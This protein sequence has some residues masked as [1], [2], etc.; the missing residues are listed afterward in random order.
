MQKGALITALPMVVVGDAVMRAVL[1]Q[2]EENLGCVSVMV[3]A[4]DV[5][6]KIA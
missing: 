3:V 5:R 1:E 2:Q 4:R 6:M